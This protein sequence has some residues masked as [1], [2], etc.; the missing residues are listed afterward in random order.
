[1]GMKFKFFSKKTALLPISTDT[2]WSA[3]GNST[4][5]RLF[6]VLNSYFG[7]V[8]IRRDVQIKAFSRRYR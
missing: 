7:S 2:S 1:M 6:L 5:R 8:S 4:S 3:E